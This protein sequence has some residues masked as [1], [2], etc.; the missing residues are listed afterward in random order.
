MKKPSL[1][2]RLRAKKRNRALL[3][4]MTWY[5]ESTW[6]EVKATALDPESFEESFPKWK[7]MALTAIREF[8]RSG[9][10][11]VEYQ[12]NP[13]EFFLWCDANNQV[14]NSASRAEFVSQKL[15]AAHDKGASTQLPDS[16]VL[17]E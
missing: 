16:T 15:S 7:A 5:T 6:A 10:Q 11:A 9:V 14:N 4:G 2:Q 3:V 17:A 8:L 1:M 12:I 13:Q